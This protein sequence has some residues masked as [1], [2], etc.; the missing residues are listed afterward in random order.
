MADETNPK[1]EVKT[2]AKP[3]P[4][5]IGR[6]SLSEVDVALLDCEKSI[7]L[8]S[9]TVKAKLNGNAAIPTKVLQ[10]LSRTNGHRGKLMMRRISLLIEGGDAAVMELLDKLMKVK[11]A[12]AV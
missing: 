11:P 3:K 7:K 8:C 10:E 9:D 5:P 4:T 1:L 6:L 12:K 2:D